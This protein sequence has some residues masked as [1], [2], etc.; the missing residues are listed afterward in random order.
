[1]AY[2]YAG[3]VVC[4][5]FQDVAMCSII[6]VNSR[7]PNSE[8]RGA[9]TDGFSGHEVAHLRKLGILKRPQPTRFILAVS[10][11]TDE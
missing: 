4:L 8:I 7:L 11:V 3:D 2:L 1:M 9:T 6:L 5:L 10:V